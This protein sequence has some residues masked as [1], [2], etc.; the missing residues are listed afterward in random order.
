M[1]F[2]TA[3]RTGLRIEIFPYHKFCQ[4]QFDCLRHNDSKF[5]KV[6]VDIVYFHFANFEMSTIILSASFTHLLGYIFPTHNLY[7]QND[8]LGIY[9]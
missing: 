6:A 9:K 5:V 7:D 8:M 2:G 4:Y 3:I 1:R